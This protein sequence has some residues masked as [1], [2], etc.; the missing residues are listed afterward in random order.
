MCDTTEICTYY[1][2]E[3]ETACGHIFFFALAV[4]L[5]MLSLMICPLCIWGVL[6]FS[7]VFCL[8]YRSINLVLW[9]CIV[10]LWF[11]GWRFNFGHGFSM[12]WN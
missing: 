5:L 3:P 1:F 11:M 6:V 4:M 10:V 7:C 2:A 8:K 9:A 12:S